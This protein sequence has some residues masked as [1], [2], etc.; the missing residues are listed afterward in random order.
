MVQ[1]ITFSQIEFSSS[2]LFGVLCIMWPLYLLAS[3]GCWLQGNILANILQFYMYLLIIPV[4]VVV[5]S[6]DWQYLY[7]CC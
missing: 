5:N 6:V 3:F 4:P 1:L 7:K 2:F